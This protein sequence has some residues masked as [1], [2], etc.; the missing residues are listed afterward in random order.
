MRPN[1]LARLD[2]RG[3][4]LFMCSCDV[5]DDERYE[6][7]PAGRRQPLVVE[8]GSIDLDEVEATCRQL[9]D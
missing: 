3:P 9:E 5:F 4:D 8:V 1:D 7:S 6:R 2:S